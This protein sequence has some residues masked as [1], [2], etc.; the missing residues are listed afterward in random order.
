MNMRVMTISGFGKDS[1]QSALANFLNR[2]AQ[3]E[4]QVSPVADQLRG[5]SSVQN[6]IKNVLSVQLQELLRKLEEL[7]TEDAAVIP[8]NLG[9]LNFYRP[10]EDGSPEQAK[11]T[12]PSR[13]IIDQY[14]VNHPSSRM[15]IV[16]DAINEIPDKNAKKR[17]N[18]FAQI[19]QS[20][21]V[22][23]AEF[24]FTRQNL[25]KFLYGFEKLSQTVENHPNALA[26]LDQPGSLL[27]LRDEVVDF[28]SGPEAQY[29]WDPE[30]NG[31]LY[32]DTNL[33]I[34]DREAFD[35]ITKLEG[36]IDTAIEYLTSEAEI[37]GG[38]ASD[39]DQY[40]AGFGFEMSRLREIRDG[41]ESFRSLKS[42][43]TEQFQVLTSEL[44]A[45][46]ADIS[47]E[48]AAEYAPSDAKD[49]KILLE[50]PAEVSPDDPIIQAQDEY[51]EKVLGLPQGIESFY[52]GEDEG[53]KK[54]IYDVVLPLYKERKQIREG[55]EK[56]VNDLNRAIGI[57]NSLDDQEKTMIMDNPIEAEHYTD[58]SGKKPLQGLGDV[59]EDRGIDFVDFITRA[60]NNQVYNVDE[61][62]TSSKDFIKNYMSFDQSQRMEGEK[63]DFDVDRAVFSLVERMLHEDR[64]GITPGFSQDEDFA[65]LLDSIEAGVTAQEKGGGVDANGKK[66]SPISWI[67]L[68]RGLDGKLANSILEKEKS[69]AEIARKRK[70]GETN[71]FEDV[72]ALNKIN[73]IYSS[74]GN[75][76]E[77]IFSNKGIRDNLQ[78][79]NANIDNDPSYN[80]INSIAELTKK[81]YGFVPFLK[82]AEETAKKSYE[83][84][85][86]MEIDS[87]IKNDFV[88]VTEML[89]ET[90]EVLD[91]LSREQI[92]HEVGGDFP[93]PQ[94]EEDIGQYPQTGQTRP[95]QEYIATLERIKR[96]MSI[97]KVTNDKYASTFVNPEWKETYKGSDLDFSYDMTPELEAAF[98]SL[99][100]FTLDTLSDPDTFGRYLEGLTWTIDS[101]YNKASNLVDYV[102]GISEQSRGQLDVETPES[103][104]E[105]LDMIE[106]EYSEGE[107]DASVAGKRQY[108]GAASLVGMGLLDEAK[109]IWLGMINNYKQLVSQLDFQDNGNGVKIPQDVISKI[110]DVVLGA[111]QNND[112]IWGDLRGPAGVF[113]KDVEWFTENMI[114]PDPAF[115]AVNAKKSKDIREENLM[116][117]EQMEKEWKE[118]RQ[119]KLQDAFEEENARRQENGE[120]MIEDLEAFK[121]I[122]EQERKN[123]NS[124]GRQISRRSIPNMFEFLDVREKLKPKEVKM[125][126]GGVPIEVYEESPGEA[127]GPV[128]GRP[129]KRNVEERGFRSEEDVPEGVDNPQVAV[130]EPE[131]PTG[132]TQELT[133]EQQ[134]AVEKSTQQPKRSR[135][136]V[137]R[138][139]KSSSFNM[140]RISESIVKEKKAFNYSEIIKKSYVEEKKSF[141]MKRL[142]EKC[143]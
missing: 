78:S 24:G 108:Q 11:V 98:Q 125:G 10:G 85:A 34:Q 76:A 79:L 26:T 74:L 54:F 126:P 113:L 5:R 47:G 107:S 37:A 58:E 49:W 80:I 116:M 106:K 140:K 67:A 12:L 138:R 99:G 48:E 92:Y 64:E 39:L 128:W 6:Y 32:R 3:S 66:I 132:Q 69:V 16:Y 40:E 45:M 44:G 129:K 22:N 83:K 143:L 29:V 112:H 61:F 88:Q 123:Y 94:T 70:Q 111:I 17:A 8:S 82:N 15:N 19:L 109:N 90:R 100:S 13:R 62:S 46:V 21:L 124:S 130:E 142:A 30:V 122:I 104:E 51:L 115:Y 119:F 97:I 127:F 4:T 38:N 101:L 136:P 2:T 7:P 77:I 23:M 28:L 42:M 57:F 43:P 33:L 117:D 68:D 102:T 95:I 91:S 14:V 118:A 135:P 71:I 9:F 93:E 89:A 73:E 81:I 105:S 86:P 18:S 103:T 59:L 120:P 41:L 36:N 133:P 35:E 20:S 131:A 114:T 72:T 25:Q 1:K 56:I 121:Q 53:T 27:D 55:D 52:S 75:E 134:K 110:K 137:G 96:Q 84:R 87:E 50:E 65:Q 31:S 60:Q 63:R 141:N 139:M